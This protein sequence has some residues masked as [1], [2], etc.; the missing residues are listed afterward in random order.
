MILC[1]VGNPS[2]LVSRTT[3]EMQSRSLVKGKATSNGSG[4]CSATGDYEFVLHEDTSPAH[5][6]VR[7]LP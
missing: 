7:K 4:E 1:L 5:F 6:S 2:C 3:Y